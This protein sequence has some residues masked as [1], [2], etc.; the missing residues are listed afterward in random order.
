VVA[1]ACALAWKSFDKETE[2]DDWRLR[3][4]QILVEGVRR[5]SRRW[6]SSPR[7]PAPV[8]V[9]QLPESCREVIV[10]IDGQGFTY[11][12]TA[13]ILDISIESLSESLKRGRDLLLQRFGTPSPAAD[14][15]P[16]ALNLEAAP[17]QG[18]AQND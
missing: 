5:K 6:F 3:L 16:P 2:H 8:L 14:A 4:F 11:R 12:E 17:P 10:L 13:Q 7:G 9:G 15:F 1:D 18:S